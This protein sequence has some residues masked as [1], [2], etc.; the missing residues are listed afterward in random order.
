MT[1]N[2]PQDPCTDPDA[3]YRDNNVFKRSILR[4]LCR[5]VPSLSTLLGKVGL[6]D[7]TGADITT[8]NPLPVAA[9]VS[10]PGGL[11]TEATLAALN[12]K[13]TTCNTGSVT[14]ASMPTVTTT[15]PAG[16]ATE[17]TL[18]ALNAKVTICNTGA[19]VGAVSVTNAG[20][21]AAVNIQDGGNSITVDGAI[22]STDTDWSIRVDEGATY[23]YFGFAATGTL[24]GAASWKIKRMTNADTTVLWAD[25]NNNQDNIWTNRAA[26]AYS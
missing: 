2:Y 25:G 13:V 15:L 1:L 8:I 21:G 14:I 20:G 5:M 26:L 11:A 22:I 9:T 3:H 12:A 24:D 16:A 4:I 23:T 6:V 10:I 18:A 19:I 7:S 17:A